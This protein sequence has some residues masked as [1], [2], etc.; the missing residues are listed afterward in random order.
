MGRP[1]TDPDKLR[2]YK[3]ALKAWKA[4]QAILQGNGAASSHGDRQ[5]KR[6]K[7][8]SAKKAKHLAAGDKPD[9]SPK[10]KKPKAPRASKEPKPVVERKGAT[11]GG[12]TFEKGSQQKNLSAADLPAIISLFQSLGIQRLVGVGFDIKLTAKTENPSGERVNKPGSIEGATANPA[13]PPLTA[14]VDQEALR[15]LDMTQKLIDSPLEYEQAQIDAHL[16]QD[17]GGHQQENHG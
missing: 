17:D 15:D 13:N 2:D 6:R 3:F 14:E 16:G 12:T 10:P 5:P 9:K 8:K 11:G 7:A 1:P 4:T